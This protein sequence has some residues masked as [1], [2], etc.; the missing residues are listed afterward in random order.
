MPGDD[1]RK[2]SI[3]EVQQELNRQV[4]IGFGKRLVELES[5]IHELELCVHDLK[6]AASAADESV[7]RLHL[8]VAQLMRILDHVD[9]SST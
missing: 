7:R 2:R 1:G 9:G 5:K 6:G 4:L 8:L 3:D